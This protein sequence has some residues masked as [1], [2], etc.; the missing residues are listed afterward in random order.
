MFSCCCSSDDLYG[1]VRQSLTDCLDEMFDNDGPYPNTD[2]ACLID[3]QNNKM[4]PQISNYWESS[5]LSLVSRTEKETSLK[6]QILCIWFS[7]SKSQ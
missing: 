2:V 5:K 7:I 1:K 6:N 3:S 4:F